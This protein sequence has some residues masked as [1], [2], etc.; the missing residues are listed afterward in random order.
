MDRISSNFNYRGLTLIELM[1][2]LVI[3]GVTVSLVAPGMQQ[4]IH[5][6]RLRTQTSRLL[7]ALNMARN[8]AVYRN[9][10]V[11]L[12]PSTMAASGVAACS[13]HYGDGWI[14]F[15]NRNKDA[16]LD[17]GTDQL[18]A[19]FESIPEGYKLTNRD[20]THRVDALITY[21]PDGSSRRNLTL[22]VCAPDGY[23]GE[24]WLVILN[25]VGRARAEEGEGPC[26]VGTI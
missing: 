16:V 20:G 25:N 13:G 21:L 10:A 2:T 8:E 15:T 6:G 9:V 1:V 12:C 18:I 23:G 17:A 5:A 22:R 7:D 24:P 11:S 19:A 14:V 4:L 3:L 26:A